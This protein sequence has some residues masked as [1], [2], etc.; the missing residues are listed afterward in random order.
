MP[1]RRRVE[2]VGRSMKVGDL[3]QYIV[4]REY[5]L[6]VVVE[7]CDGTGHLWV[8]MLSL[9]DGKVSAELSTSLEI[10]NERI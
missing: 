5:G 10:V 6:F 1:H 7:G 8:K 3:V 4:W 9:R 2:N